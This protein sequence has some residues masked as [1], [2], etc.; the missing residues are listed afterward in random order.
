MTLVQSISAV[1]CT[2]NPRQDLLLRALRSVL[3][4]DVDH[5]TFAVCVIDN[6]SSKPVAEMPEVQ[7]LGI[8]VVREE[9]PGLTAARECALRNCQSDLILFIDDDNII[10]PNYIRSVLD[11]MQD[12]SIGVLGA[13]IEP[14]YESPPPLWVYSLEGSLAI[15]RFASKD[16]LVTRS[17]VYSDL[18]P[19]G[20]GFCVRRSVLERYFEHSRLAGRVEGRLGAELSSGEDIDIDLLALSM[21]MVLAVSQRLNVTHV[22]PVRRTTADYFCRLVVGNA[23]S[24][25]K[26]NRK[27][28]TQYRKNVFPMF[29]T[30]R[31][32]LLA[33]QIAC[34]PLAFLPAFRIR[35]AALRAIDR[36]RSVCQ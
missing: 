32:V 3:E 22:I 21:G 2:H 17:P 10:A 12:D 25:A 29:D 20:A 15:R 6:C 4:Q 8:T 30:P 9:T 26:I 34:L 27:W 1:V 5:G 16:L 14:E 36:A 11:I 13:Q 24:A 18:F 33:K 23:S 31:L 19:V 28:H 35:L 7:A